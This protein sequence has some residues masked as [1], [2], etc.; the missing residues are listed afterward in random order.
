M[1]VWKK[2]KRKNRIYFFNVFT[3]FDLIIKIDII[4]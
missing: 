4:L 3:S 2:L 1:G